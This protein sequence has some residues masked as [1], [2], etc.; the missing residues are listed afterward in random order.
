M[1]EAIS[2][3]EDAPQDTMIATHGGVIA[4]IMAHLSRV[5]GK[6]STSGSRKT[7]AAIWSKAE[8]TGPF[9]K[10]EQR[11]RPARMHAPDKEVI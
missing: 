2:K 9:L 1:L 10:A 4:A 7:A 8:A 11:K 5:K 6:I 3:W